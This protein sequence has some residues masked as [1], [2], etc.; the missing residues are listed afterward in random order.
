[1]H[2]QNEVLDNICRWHT[3]SNCPRGHVQVG[4]AMQHLLVC[5][6]ATTNGLCIG[7]VICAQH[8]SLRNLIAETKKELG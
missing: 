6:M 5:I 2:G 4:Y 7:A 3:Q 1:M 8:S